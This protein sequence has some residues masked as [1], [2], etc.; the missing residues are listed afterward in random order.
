MLKWKGVIAGA[1]LC[2]GV[3]ADKVIIQEPEQIPTA[4]FTGPLLASSALP[5]PAGHWYIEPYF[6]AVAN[7]G[8]Y[9]GDWNAISE[10]TL[11]NLSLQPSFQVG[12]T[13]WMDFQINPILYYNFTDG[14]ASWRVG[15]V[16]VVVDLLLKKWGR[17]RDRW[18][19]ALKI[20]FKET[21]P[22]G[23]YQ[24]LNPYKYQTDIGGQG[25][26]NTTFG[27]VWGSLLYVKGYQ[28]FNS[29]VSL[30]YSLPAPV[31]VKDYNSYG[32]GKEAHAKV[33]PAQN[34]ELDI[35][36]EY[37]LNRN[38]ALALDLVGSWSGLTRFRGDPGRETD[39]TPG[40]LQHGS[41][42]QFSLAPA[43]E[44][45]WSANIGIIAGS[46]FTVAGRNCVQFSSGIIAFSYYN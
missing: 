31:Y 1:I 42:A 40:S 44:Y 25:T 5:I 13:Q 35:G 7:T 12:L 24:K 6:Y 26:F 28:F 9:D 8:S 10:D 4:W 16:S 41:S 34:F 45:N 32:G 15:D 20:S 22:L 33:Y 46:W 30:Q 29:R 14:A 2:T 18:I 43:I 36:L 23:K 27:L 3:Y 21:F 38:W 37:S 17:D 19:N 39:G 11:W